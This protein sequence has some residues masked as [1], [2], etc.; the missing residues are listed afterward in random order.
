[1]KYIKIILFAVIALQ[2]A[3]TSGP[4]IKLKTKRDGV[5]T[6]QEPVVIDKGKNPDGQNNIARSE[7][8]MPP[9]LGI[10]LGPGS[11]KAFAHTGVLKELEKANIPI[12]YIVGIEWGALVGAM[13]ASSAKIN[14]TE[15]KLYKLQATKLG[16]KHWLLGKEKSKTVEAYSAFIKN[17]LANAKFNNLKIPFACPSISIWSGVTVW[18]EA[19]KL[20]RAIER[21]MPSP[22]LFQP[23]SPWM[24]SLFSSEEAVK[25][26]RKKGMDVVLYVDVLGKGMPL[27]T[28]EL[29]AEFTSALLWQ[30]LRNDVSR[31]KNSNGVVKAEVKTIKFKL[32]DFSARSSLSSAGSQAGRRAVDEIVQNYN[33]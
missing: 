24:A 23:K 21:C 30:E 33:F 17:N 10:V 12:S 3:C 28:E 8:D 22:P 15:W 6:N 20:Q 16:K 13:Y 1:M 29:M 4:Q 19:G 5:T 9:K 25:F 18:Q 31:I 26:L 2:V 7:V 32:Y 27:N 14:D 11:V